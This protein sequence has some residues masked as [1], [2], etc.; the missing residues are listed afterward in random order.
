M[1]MA[2]TIT[3]TLMMA[4]ILQ[5]FLLFALGPKFFLNSYLQTFAALDVKDKNFEYGY[6][7]FLLIIS[8][9]M[10]TMMSMMIRTRIN[11]CSGR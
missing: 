6:I 5:V 11:L 10:L 1:T 2:M 9:M 8:M 7:F 3:R 4:M